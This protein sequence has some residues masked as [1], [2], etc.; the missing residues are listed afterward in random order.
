MQQ[1]EEPQQRWLHAPRSRLPLQ[2][3]RLSHPPHQLLSKDIRGGGGG[4]AT[5]LASVRAAAR[6]FV[7][8]L[9]TKHFLVAGM[10]VSIVLAAMN[11]AVR[12]TGR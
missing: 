4:A 8:P 5:R 11:P 9:V 3:A 10:F 2:P 7:T 12:R 6:G 1:Q